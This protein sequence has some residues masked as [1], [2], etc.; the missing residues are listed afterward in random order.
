M[1]RHMEL[2]VRLLVVMITGAMQLMDNKIKSLAARIKD[3]WTLCSFAGMLEKEVMIAQT[4]HAAAYNLDEHGEAFSIRGDNVFARGNGGL[5]DNN[6]AYRELVTDG[7]FREEKRMID[8][9][10][11]T[12]IFLSESLINRLESFLGKG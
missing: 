1:L 3:N 6:R 7:S 8:G 11:A 4:V 2:C 10:E 9:K 12:V 5:V